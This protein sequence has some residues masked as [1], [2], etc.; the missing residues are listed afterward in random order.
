ML[1][2]GI[3]INPQTSDIYIRTLTRRVSTEISPLSVQFRSL[4]RLPSFC[5]TL[6]ADDYNPCIL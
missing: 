2:T 6:G 5:Q 1:L 3:F 4:G